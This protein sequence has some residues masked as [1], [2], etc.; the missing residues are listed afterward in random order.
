M[1]KILL[2]SDLHLDETIQNEYR[3]NIF[4]QIR[5]KIKEHNLN[6][7]YILGDLTDKK[8]RHSSNFVNRMVKEISSLRELLSF[9]SEVIF[10]AGNHDYVDQ[11][12]PFFSLLKYMGITCVYGK[13]LENYTKPLNNRELFLPHVKN[14]QEIYS[15]I[16]FSKYNIC[17]THLDVKGTKL[18]NGM[19]SLEGLPIS[20]FKN[21]LT[22]SGH[23]HVGQ[24]VKD[25]FYYIGSPYSIIYEREDILHRGIILT[26]DKDSID[27]KDT[28]FNFPRKIV[29]S[30]KSVEDV[31]QLNDNNNYKLEIEVDKSEMEI[32]NK[33]N[34]EMSNKDNVKKVNVKVK[35][36]N[37]IDQNNMR[38]SKSK[39]YFKR[40]VADNEISDKLIKIGK[41]IMNNSD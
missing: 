3:W 25:N 33:I 40:Y 28:Y 19:K 39:D 20:F 27:F 32:V 34:K 12:N 35:V 10:L 24:K 31:K 5:D 1:K 13:Q 37:M 9:T 30:I 29:K 18:E 6:S 4:N 16:D 15:N 7:I 26:Y 36:N 22:F 38:N 23:I 14:P 41:E 17:F 2:I 8:D 21:T 11:N